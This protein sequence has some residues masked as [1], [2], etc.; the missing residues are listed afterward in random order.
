[1]LTAKDIM[2]RE[3]I[4]VDPVLPVEKLAALFYE[5]KIGGAPVIDADNNLLGVVTESDLIDQAKNI[6]IPTAVAILDSFLFLENPSKMDQEI[7]K[8]AGRTVEDIYSKELV[9]VNVDT[10]LSEIATIMSEKKIHTVPVLEDGELSGV[11]GKSD[12]IR[13]IST[14]C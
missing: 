6:H 1:M 12:L 3:V 7:K 11:V 10:P 8:M 9:T 14:G 4:S 13:A 2:T 5:K